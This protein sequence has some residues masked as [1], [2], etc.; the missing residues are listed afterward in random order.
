MFYINL[1]CSFWIEFNLNH[2][3]VPIVMDTGCSFSVTPFLGDIIGELEQ[4]DVNEMHGLK[5]S[6]KVTGMGLAKWP[7]RDVF[8]RNADLLVKCYVI[9]DARVWLCSTQSYFQQHWKRPFWQKHEK[10]TKLREILM[11]STGRIRVQSRQSRLKLP[12]WR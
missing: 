2:P 1:K 11:S 4:A 9:P 5:D 10:P 8:G 7:I 3:D 6:C 12:E